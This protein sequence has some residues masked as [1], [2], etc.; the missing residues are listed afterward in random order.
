MALLLDI[1]PVAMA[2]NKGNRNQNFA[3]A[4]YVNDRPY[5]ASSFMSTAISKVLGSAMSGQCKTHPELA[6]QEIPIEVTFDV[7]PVRGGEK[8]LQSMFEPLG[9]TVN[10]K[11][12]TLD[13]QF[14][15]WGD[16][17]YYSVHLQTC[18]KLASV[19]RHLYVLIPVFDNQK[20]YFVSRGELEKL[21]DKGKGWLDACLLYTSPSPRDLSTSRMPSSA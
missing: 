17:Q 4:G 6:K 5:V 3:L 14:P 18:A 12:L 19:L 2:R 21:L 20:H 11:R 16:S 9:Y 7:L 10:A 13:E 1:D 15:E 8:F